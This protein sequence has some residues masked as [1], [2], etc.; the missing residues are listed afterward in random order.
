MS[1]AAILVH[2][3]NDETAQPRL[4]CACALAARFE[5][6]LIGVGAEM[7][8]PM[9]TGSGAANVDAGWYVAMR[10]IVEA[11]LK[12]AA[13]RFDAASANIRSG[14]IWESGLDLPAQAVARS[15]R[16]ADLIVASVGPG[17]RNDPY[18]DAGPAD[19]ALLTGRPVLVAHAGSAPLSAKRI[20][21]AWK[22]TR[23]ARRAMSDAM[24]FLESAESVL[25]LEVCP[26][27]DKDEAKIRTDEVVEALRRHK[28][29]A[30][31][32]VVIHQ[33]AD[34]SQVVLQAKAFG[35]DLII[36][37]AYGHSRLGEW[38]FGGMT[39]DLLRQDDCYV[40]L[41]H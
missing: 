9:A 7:I 18:R 36:A 6:A 14:A 15:S 16:A 8:Q 41:S 34:S 35:A 1:Y 28:V 11:E 32:K 20:V 25:V 17:G 30:E 5:A 13:D 22:D 21:L 40:L 29:T 19:L 24:P 4:R 39:R 33:H 31:A 37:G 12:G 10:D 3:Q 27:E 38:V 23:E 2:V 26:E